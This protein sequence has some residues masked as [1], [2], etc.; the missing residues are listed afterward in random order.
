M[1]EQAA[2]EMR[3]WAAAAST[4]TAAGT[5]EWDERS[6]YVQMSRLVEIMM[7][8]PYDIIVM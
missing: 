5:R 2:A 1:S 8:D 7:F 6:S 4:D 3:M